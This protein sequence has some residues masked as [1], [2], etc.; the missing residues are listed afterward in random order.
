MLDGELN[1]RASLLDQIRLDAT[2]AQMRIYYTIKMFLEQCMDRS[3]ALPP[4]L[5]EIEIFGEKTRTVRKTLGQYFDYG[6]AICHPVRMEITPRMLQ[7]LATVANYWARRSN[8]ILLQLQGPRHTRS[9]CHHALVQMAASRKIASRSRALD[10][11][12]RTRYCWPL[13][14]GYRWY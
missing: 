3:L 6:G 2:V 7:K 4:L 10:M 13:L 9:N 8:P 5:N 1:P 14:M 11:D 12:A